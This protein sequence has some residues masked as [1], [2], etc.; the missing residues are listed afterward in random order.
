MNAKN[1]FRPTVEALES[2]LTPTARAVGGYLVIEGTDDRDSVVVNQV[3]RPQI[4]TILIVT[5]RH[6]LQNVPLYPDLIPVAPTTVREIP[7]NDAREGIRFMG[8]GGNDSFWYTKTGR[9]TKDDL[10]VRAFGG[11]GVDDL[12]G[13]NGNDNLHGEGGDDILEGSYGDDVLV[14][15]GAADRMWGGFGYDT[16]FGGEGAAS[17]PSGPDGLDTLYGG[18]DQDHLDGGRD[19]FADRLDGGAGIDTFRAETR[20]RQYHVDH[21]VGRVLVNREY[22]R[23]ET[24][25]LDAPN[26]LDPGDIVLDDASLARLPW[27][28]RSGNG[29]CPFV[30]PA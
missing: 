20:V 12:H 10:S 30:S 27:Q 26:H 22:T 24:F 14:G 25:N 8:Y 28:A 6:Y 1:S 17:T 15:G 4:G 7:Y 29:L 23:W 11:S 3:K 18:A 16:L 13:G 2:R 9:Q 19:G 5:E 21:Y